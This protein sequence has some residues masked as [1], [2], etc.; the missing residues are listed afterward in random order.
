M[1]L[2]S[3]LEHI[4]EVSELSPLC[5]DQSRPHLHSAT[6]VSHLFFLRGVKNG[7]GKAK[8]FLWRN[9]RGFRIWIFGGY[10]LKTLG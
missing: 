4:S 7:R 2:L 5:H 8:L 9:A 6:Y 1:S 3:K 10:P